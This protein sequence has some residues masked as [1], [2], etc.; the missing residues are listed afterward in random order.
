MKKI[1]QDNL[2]TSEGNCMSACLATL[3]GIPLEDDSHT[4]CMIVFIVADDKKII[5]IQQFQENNSNQIMYRVYKGDFL[6]LNKDSDDI[7]EIA[8]INSEFI[9]EFKLE[10]FS[11]RDKDDEYK[12]KDNIFDDD[13]FDLDNVFDSDDEFSF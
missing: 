7:N 12:S 5:N 2:N 3:L 6:L 13:S 9:E 4:N 11:R 10:V 1:Y 8:Y